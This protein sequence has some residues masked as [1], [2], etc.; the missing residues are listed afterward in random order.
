L[1][2]EDHSVSLSLYGKYNIS[3]VCCYH[4]QTEGVSEW[5]SNGPEILTF[6]KNIIKNL[7]YG[8]KLLEQSDQLRFTHDSNKLKKYFPYKDKLAP[9]SPPFKRILQTN[10][11][12]R[13][14]LR[15]SVIRSR[16]P[17]NAPEFINICWSIPCI[18]LV[19]SQ[20]KYWETS[21]FKWNF[22]CTD[23]FWYRTGVANKSI[24]IDRSIAECQL[25]DRAWFCIE[26]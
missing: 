16:K 1:N 6:L 4:M 22:C 17:I 19:L 24:A 3:S 10:L 15:W 12:W 25:I 5:S 20:Q 21:S 13:I 18:D 9:R 14:Y 7:T 2:R 23:F 26:L 8:R 11:H